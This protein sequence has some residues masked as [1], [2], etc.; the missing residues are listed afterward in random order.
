[1][2]SH[3]RSLIGELRQLS[4]GKGI[5]VGSWRRWGKR[6]VR[7]TANGWETAP[8]P[9]AVPK[10]KKKSKAALAIVTRDDGHLLMLKRHAREPWMPKKW[11]LPGGGVD[12]D[13]TL[14]QAA[15]REAGE[16]AGVSVRRLKKVGKF[17]DGEGGELH[18]YHAHGHEG[19]P[20]VNHESSKLR[21][22][23]HSKAHEMNVIP[24]LKPILK[25]FSDHH[26]KKIDKK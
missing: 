6:V 16:E 18:V 13:E 23:H 24:V 22:V 21:W 17:D 9:S 15:R 11:N 2:A 20:R 25:H 10:E 12:K 1:M 19:T 26:G 7:K 5:P 8:K 3:L 4:E 14:K